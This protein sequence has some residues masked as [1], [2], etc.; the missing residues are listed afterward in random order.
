MSRRNKGSKGFMP[1]KGVNPILQK[2]E[3]ERKAKEDEQARQL[4]EAVLLDEAVKK[5]LQELDQQIAAETANY[6]TRRNELEAEYQEK[7]KKLDE[8]SDALTQREASIEKR[9]TDVLNMESALNEQREKV[10]RE[11]ESEIR[12]QEQVIRADEYASLQ[13]AWEAE[14][15]SVL[16]AATSE[17]AAQKRKATEALAAAHSSRVEAEN[18]YQN[19][20]R[21]AE[22][23][24]EKRHAELTAEYENKM[25]ELR[26]ARA[27]YAALKAE[28]DADRT[29][30]EEEQAYLQ[31]MR[32]RYESCSET[33]ILRLQ[34][35]VEH[36]EAVNRV[37]QERLTE[38]SAKL[39]RLQ[40]RAIE[41][42]GQ[43]DQER[44]DELEHQLERATQQI[45][46]Y[47]NL[48]S[49]AR[50]AELELAEIEL[51]RSRDEVDETRR[52]YEKT[53]EQLDAT[54]LSVREL[55]NAKATAT[56]LTALNDQLQKK[57]QY[58]SE[59]Y[60]STQESKFQGLLEID[61]ADEG[62]LF[63][64]NPFTGTLKDLV[65][66]V[67]NYGAYARKADPLYYSEDTIRVFL[68][69]LA[70]SDPASRL[71]ILQGLSGTGKSS[72]PTLFGEALQIH[73]D[74]VSVQPSWRDNRELL[75]YDNDFTNRFKET[76]F[77]KCVYRASTGTAQNQIVIIV[78]DEMNL[79]RIEYYF[80]DFLSVLE[81]QNADWLIPLVSS[82][83]EIDMDK[84]P[85]ALS[86]ENGTASLVVTKN[87]WFVGTANNDD[88]TS[89]I[90]DKVYDRAQIIDMD[91]REPEFAVKKVV[92][93]YL[94]M[95]TLQELFAEAK[96][97]NEGQMTT[98][99]WENLDTIDDYLKIMD[100]T[101]GNRIKN[102]MN[103]FVPIYCACGGRKED[104][105]DYYLAHK[106][107]RKLDEK[108]DVYLLKCLDS[109]IECLDE[110]YGEGYFM[111]SREK[112]KKIKQR[113]FSIGEN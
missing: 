65:Q 14:R 52:R 90:T 43:S 105:I 42:S 106:I 37:S 30:L 21:S 8:E 56:A 92:P 73:V 62:A 112:I 38:L 54:L 108:Y 35:L 29:D 1:E 87:I 20:I 25:A 41:H 103:E 61:A 86:Y 77:T 68:A 69:S 45:D 19:R 32:K 27:E 93:Y 40:T 44:I 74:F 91:S 17:V 107:L 7:R 97:N 39:A 98:D 80:A 11:T 46:E 31:T 3:E 104:A 16:K 10:A 72:L 24:V 71:I 85:R 26:A 70:A 89:L 83:S 51:R 96:A 111:Q 99:D 101:F 84:Q 2:M 66:Y 13:A 57:L 33:E 110:L 95:S 18:E 12:A 102:Q 76:E 55:E 28:L 48:P 100:I 63:T 50:V 6:T 64:G 49:P 34:Q 78:L 67:R 75:G 60:K 36:L 88:S 94:D 81:H 22:T 82:Y 23:Q 53:K 109:L 59:Q 79:A 113:N 9:E 5:K 58:I 15:I 47:A 4:E